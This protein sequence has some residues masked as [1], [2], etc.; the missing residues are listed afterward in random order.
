VRP[1]PR[2]AAGAFANISVSPNPANGVVHCEG[3]LTRDSHVTVR[4]VDVA[5]REV[6]TVLD[7]HVPAGRFAAR[8]ITDGPSGPAAPGV[9]F[10]RFEA[11]RETTAMRVALVK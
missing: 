2:D 6:A 5:G 3:V 8:W 11:G 1:P 9:Y 10:V 7:R 4:V